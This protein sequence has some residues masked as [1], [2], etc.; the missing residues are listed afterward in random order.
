MCE[1][2]KCNKPTYEDGTPVPPHVEAFEDW[3]YHVALLGTGALAGA[4]L[5]AH[6]FAQKGCVL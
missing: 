6:H 4:I 5:V 2:P 3:M 1:D